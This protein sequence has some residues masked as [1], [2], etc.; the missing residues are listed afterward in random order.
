MAQSN[1]NDC[2][3]K[4][5]WREV[6]RRCGKMLTFNFVSGYGPLL[7]AG[8]LAIF[9]GI[10]AI[11]SL[12]SWVAS[13]FVAVKETVAKIDLWPLGDEEQGTWFKGTDLWPNE[14]YNERFGNDKDV[15][16]EEQTIPSNAF[17]ENDLDVV[18]I[19]ADISVN[20]ETDESTCGRWGRTVPAWATKCK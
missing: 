1:D 7:L 18:V 6:L 9:A 14:Y 11:T 17:E 12:T 10:W 4:Q 8:T 2:T 5:P 13:P 19:P 15:A 16:L 3:S 20:T